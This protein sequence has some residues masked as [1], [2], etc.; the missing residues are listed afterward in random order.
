MGEAKQAEEL[1]RQQEQI[2]RQQAYI[3]AQENKIKALQHLV[4]AYQRG[5]FMTLMRQIDRLKR[6]IWNNSVKLK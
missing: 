5:R 3:M 6:K 4:Q 1:A 2:L